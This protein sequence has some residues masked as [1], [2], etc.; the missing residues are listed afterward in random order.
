MKDERHYSPRE[1]ATLWGVSEDFVRRRFRR[2]SDTIKCGRVYRI[3]QSAVDRV[4][5][6]FHPETRQPV[7][8]RQQAHWLADGTVVFRPRAASRRRP[9]TSPRPPAPSDPDA[10]SPTARNASR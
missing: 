8:P 5:A 10:T 6:S 7:L 2:E 3:P 4:Y 1:L 9:A